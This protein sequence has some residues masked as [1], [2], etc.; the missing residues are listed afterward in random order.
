MTRPAKEVLEALVAK[1]LSD[2]QMGLELRV[3]ARTIQRWRAHYE[4]PSQ[5]EP[6]RAPHGTASRYQSG[7]RCDRCTE[8]NT[9]VCREYRRKRRDTK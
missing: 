4:I 8:A 6:V 5:W 9:A 3:N 2:R 1:K 7:C